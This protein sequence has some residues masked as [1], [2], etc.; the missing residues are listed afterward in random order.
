MVGGGAVG[1][2]IAA[3]IMTRYKVQLH[4]FASSTVQ[5]FVKLMGVFFSE[6]IFVTKSQKLLASLAQTLETTAFARRTLNFVLF[7]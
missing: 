1:C 4:T 5:R 7:G 6:P 3:E 2:E